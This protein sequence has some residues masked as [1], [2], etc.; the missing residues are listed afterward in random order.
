MFSDMLE[1]ANT[2]NSIGALADALAIEIDSNRLQSN[3]EIV[4]DKAV[5]IGIENASAEEVVSIINS[6]LDTSSADVELTV[7]E[8]AC[9]KCAVVILNDSDAQELS[10]LSKKGVVEIAASPIFDDGEDEEEEPED[11][12]VADP[13]NDS[14]PEQEEEDEDAQADDDDD[15]NKMKVISDEEAFKLASRLHAL[16]C[17]QDKR[18]FAHFLTSM[19]KLLYGFRQ[20]SGYEPPEEE[21]ETAAAKAY[22]S[23]FELAISLIDKS[24]EKKSKHKEG[25]D[26]FLSAYT[27][28]VTKKA[29]E[30]ADAHDALDVETLTHLLAE[31]GADYLHI[32]SQ[33]RKDRGLD[34]GPLSK[35]DHEKVAK[36]LEEATTKRFITK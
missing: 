36:Q 14:D 9:G 19:D 5:K 8:S 27:K 16:A 35:D 22:D 6:F 18:G 23:V 11:E 30:L 2:Q 10:E 24:S 29:D 7:V 17:G 25:R 28:I 20:S 21:E 34:D 31:A 4:S 1:V 33:E 32:I 3:T 12:H 26:G 13:D 15:P